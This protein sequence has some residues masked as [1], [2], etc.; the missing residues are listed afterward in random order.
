[1][2]DETQE[3]SAGGVKIAAR[4]PLAGMRKA[5]AQHMLAS[6][7]GVPAVTIFGELD[8]APL[9][10]FKRA[11]SHNPADGVKISY[12]HF[13]MKAVALA[14]QEH[15][16]LNAT[17]AADHIQVLAQINIG[18]AVGKSVA[19]IAHEA[20]QLADAARRGALN[21]KHVRGATFT[22]SNV[23]MIPGT[24][25]QTPLINQAQCAILA[26]GEIRRIPVVRDDQIVIGDVISASLTFDHR[27]VSGVPA[28]SFV[29]TL[30]KLLADPQQWAS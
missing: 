9:I 11:A 1:M 29:A 4:I 16:L 21:V 18:M 22:I 23:G 5:I 20:T 3:L 12:T 7:Q 8:M 13:F 2:Q 24:R 28:S 26:L 15:P 10:A 6:H 30:S 25:W 27:I 19:E 14:L 17:L